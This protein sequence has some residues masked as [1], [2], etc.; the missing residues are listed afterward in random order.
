MVKTEETRR[1]NSKRGRSRRTA[2]KMR[3]NKK[4][5]GKMMMFGILFC[6]SAS[7]APISRI[8]IKGKIMTTQIQRPES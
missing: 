7:F 6:S 2:K 3:S 5:G 4:Y 8:S 1:E